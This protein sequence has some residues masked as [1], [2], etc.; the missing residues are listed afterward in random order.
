MDSTALIQAGLRVLND[1]ARRR[2]LNSRDV[3]MLRNHR[4]S[5]SH[6]A[7]LAELACEIIQRELSKRPATD[8]HAPSRFPAE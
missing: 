8:S 6:A 4:D 5:G 7:T 1:L 2:D 3:Q